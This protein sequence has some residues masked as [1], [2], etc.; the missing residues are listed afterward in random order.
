MAPDVLHTALIRLS[1]FAAIF[2]IA[3]ALSD[4]GAMHHEAPHDARADMVHADGMQDDTSDC[5]GEACDLCDSTG[6]DHFAEHC[7]D[8]LAQ[9]PAAPETMRIDRRTS[10]NSPDDS[11][12]CAKDDTGRAAP[13]PFLSSARSG[14]SAR[15]PILRL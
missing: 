4:V 10:P 1:A 2:L 5:T 7:P 12:A 6:G 15:S 9:V 14:L 11:D 8:C 3:G 13:T